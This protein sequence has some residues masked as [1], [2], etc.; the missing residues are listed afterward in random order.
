MGVADIILGI[1]IVR[2]GH[3][4]GLSPSHYIEKILK[5]F[6]EFEGYSVST[7]FDPSI[8][9]VPNTGSS[10]SQIEYAKIIGC[11]IYALTC[12]RPDIVYVV[13]CLSRYTDNSSKDHWHAVRR[14][15]KYLKGTINYILLYS[16]EPSILEGYT[17]ASWINYTED[18]ASTSGWIFT[19]GGGAIFWDPRNK[20]A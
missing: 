5:N 16:G 7:P 13:G 8:K 10:V 20:L 17:D 14:I 12:T 19:L 3:N 15:L 1:K 6:D 11:L 2:D 9:F 18:H 4:L